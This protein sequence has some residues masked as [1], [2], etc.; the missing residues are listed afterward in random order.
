MA[1][2]SEKKAR[3][4]G[5]PIKP[6]QVLNPGGRPKLDEEY[7][8]LVKANTVAAM[9]VVISLLSSDRED[10]K[11]KAAQE[12][13]DRAYGKAAQP[14]V[15]SDDHDPINMRV[16]QDL[17]RLSDVELAQLEQLVDKVTN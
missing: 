13:I 15:G 6:G 2:K 5:R 7:K 4:P 1:E 9:Q 8:A 12:I 17:T 10:I 11:L 3:G 16:K 14:I